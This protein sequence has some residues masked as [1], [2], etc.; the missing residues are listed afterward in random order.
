MDAF[1]T[2]VEGL[3]RQK[4]YWTWLSYKI[5]LDK[6]EK[7]KI[8]KPSMPRPE[9]DIV[10]Y[11]PAK[12]ELLWIECKS[13]LDSQGVKLD[14]VRAEN[15]RFKVFSNK[16]YRRIVSE[17]LIKQIV[18]EGLVLPNPT[19]K[20]CLVA[21][22]TYKKSR[23]ELEAHFRENGWDLYNE[24]WIKERLREFSTRGYENDIAVVVAKL[25]KEEM[26]KGQR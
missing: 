15:G 8:G 12:N 2:I 23:V 7:K 11:K 24:D 9:I 16:E 25:L 4:G 14:S 26:I 17:H 21:G 5:K 13:Y 20:Y 3:F 1:E 10:A 6:D 19:L 18:S 22:H